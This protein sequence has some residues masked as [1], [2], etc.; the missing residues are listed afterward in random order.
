MADAEEEIEEVV[1]DFN[2]SQ[3]KKALGAPWSM[4][5]TT[6][7]ALTLAMLLAPLLLRRYRQAW[8]MTRGEAPGTPTLDAPLAAI[9][10]AAVSYA[11]T[12]QKALQVAL[13]KL[14][15]TAPVPEVA[16]I[17]HGVYDKAATRAAQL[18][19]TE[20]HRATEAGKLAAWQAAGTALWGVWRVRSSTPC[21]HCLALDGRRVPLGQVFFHKGDTSQDAAGKAMKLDYA[22]VQT[23][24]LHPACQCELEAE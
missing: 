21:G 12:T 5:D 2:E 14:P 23:P 6:E 15:A 1:Q 7:A 18:A 22:D 19:A 16:A 20:V 17:V 24:P 3:R 13:R 4:G 8:Q 10:H 11:I 9:Q